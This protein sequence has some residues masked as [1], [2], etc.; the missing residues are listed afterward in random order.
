[1]SVELTKLLKEQQEQAQTYLMNPSKYRSNEGPLFSALERSVRLNQD[2]VTEWGDWHVSVGPL[3]MEAGLSREQILEAAN[4][5]FGHQQHYWGDPDMVAAVQKDHYPSARRVL[6]WLQLD[7]L[8]PLFA[9]KKA[10][11]DMEIELVSAQGVNAMGSYRQLSTDL[12]LRVKVR[13]GQSVSR[14][15]TT[16]L[17]KWA[18]PHPQLVADIPKLLE[19][20]GQLWAV[21]Q[22]QMWQVVFSCAPMDIMGMGTWGEGGSCYGPGGAH[23]SSKLVLMQTPT[24]VVVK[25]YKLEDGKL[26]DPHEKPD[27]RAWGF[28]LDGKGLMVSNIYR[29]YWEQAQP[30]MERAVQELLGLDSKDMHTKVLEDRS[31]KGMLGGKAYSNGDERLFGVKELQTEIRN[32]QKALDARRCGTCAMVA[33]EEEESRKCQ[34]CNTKTCG[35]CSQDVRTGSGPAVYCQNCIAH[36][37]TKRCSGCNETFMVDKNSADSCQTCNGWYCD[38]CK[39]A[40]WELKGGECPTC[41]LEEETRYA[42]MKEVEAAAREIYATYEPGCSCAACQDAFRRAGG[43]PVEAA[44]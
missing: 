7:Y 44:A 36:M 28:L 20:L 35:G 15:V 23:E 4:A 18:L 38:G 43:Q 10:I 31:G 1:M 2:R 9:H 25:I 29:L 6:F 11:S 21:S 37:K 16:A 5:V 30:I 24:A 17:K 32:L 34:N 12:A 40:T 27:A 26:R 22:G 14:A 8:A 3:Q 13:A 19:R 39:P 33:L 41:R 42:R